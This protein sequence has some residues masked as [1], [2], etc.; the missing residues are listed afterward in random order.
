MIGRPFFKSG[1]TNNPV[2]LPQTTPEQN[3]E[4][5]NQQNT[6]YHKCCPQ[7]L[8]YNLGGTSHEQP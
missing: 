2:Y 5:V 4:C 7:F 8:S 6:V 3:K 1:G